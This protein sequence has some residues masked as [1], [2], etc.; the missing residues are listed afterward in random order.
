MNL[1]SRDIGGFRGLRLPWS[2][3]G[4]CFFAVVLDGF[5]TSMMG[6]SVPA[7]AESW[8]VEKAAFT[9]PL[10]LT[11][12]GVVVGYFT[13]GGV[14]ARVGARNLLVWATA[15]CGLFTLAGGVAILVQ[16]MELLSATRVVTG[17]AIGWVLPVANSL[18]AD[19]SPDEHRQ[20]VSVMVTL[21]L[22]VGLVAGGALG[23]P[24][25]A[26]LGAGG[27][28]WFGGAA[29]IFATVAVVAVVR[30]PQAGTAPSKVS[31]SM[32]RL[33]ESGRS[34]NTILLW[35]FAF[36]VFV[37][38]YTMQ[39]W[40]PTFLVDYGMSSTQAP[41]GIA[42]WSFG[43]IFGGIALIPLTAKIGIARSLIL[44]SVIG[45][46]AIVVAGTANLGAGVGL[47]VLLVVA[48]LGT[49]ACKIGQLSL[50]VAIYPSA[51]ATT[52][53]G[54]AAGV[55]R[56]GSIVGP[57]IGGVLIAQDMAA[58][59]IMLLSAAPVLIAAACAGVLSYRLSSRRAQRAVEE[60]A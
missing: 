11:N 58:D 14:A 56:M 43:G 35:T 8:G 29:S 13:A 38:T 44:M 28:F 31:A 42:L 20:R 30:E 54:A 39:S 27:M 4:A 55:G 25:V 46:A 9:V 60:V 12:V 26:A 6:A 52:G 32:V 15:I 59:Q 10:V 49:S 41:I 16:S 37:S 5:D 7:L 24:M 23:G 17:L 36:T 3:I 2:I 18:A 40:L 33:F 34:V 47:F 57:A 19:N 21:G 48:G 51:N 22:S 53:I 45:A 1:S 50:A